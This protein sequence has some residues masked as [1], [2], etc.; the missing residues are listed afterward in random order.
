MHNSGLMH[1]YRYK[2]AKRGFPEQSM[3][4]KMLSICFFLNLGKA[5]LVSRYKYYIQTTGFTYVRIYTNKSECNRNKM[6]DLCHGD[7][8]CI[9]VRA[10]VFYE[11][12]FLSQFYIYIYC[13]I[14]YLFPFDD[15]FMDYLANRNVCVCVFIL[16]AMLE[17]FVRNEFQ[18]TNCFNY[19]RS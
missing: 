5:Q 16:S 3:V 8:C 15:L 6:I 9:M 13:N 19:W 17:Y 2:G 18:H 4:Y 12:Y 11:L 14:I 7:V 10:M 1:K